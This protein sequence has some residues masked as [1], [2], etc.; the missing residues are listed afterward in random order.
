MA[1]QSLECPNC[2]A[3][4]PDLAGRATVVCPH[5]Q[6]TLHATPAGPGEPAQPVRLEVEAPLQ[7]SPLASVTRVPPADL[8]RIRQLLHEQRK[9]EAVKVYREAMGGSLAEAKNAVDAIQAGLRDAPPAADVASAAAS[10]PDSELLARVRNLLA[11]GNKIEAIKF[12]RAATGVGLAEAKAAVEAIEVGQ[13]PAL[14]GPPATP[15][16]PD[17]LDRVRNLL[18]AGNKIE[19]IKFYRAATGVGLAEAKNTVE[20]I[21]AGTPG[22]RR[23]RRTTI[24]RGPFLTVALVMLICGGCNAYIQN[25]AIYRCAMREL[26]TDAQVQELLGGEVRGSPVMVSP[27]FS[28]E[29][30]FDG[31]TDTDVAFFT[32]LWGSR[33]TGVAYVEAYMRGSSNSA[34]MRATLFT[35]FKRHTLTTFQRI[36]CP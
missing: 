25:T 29:V 34:G 22:L 9:I 21:E 18:A 17:V 12:Y 16:G 2:G 35:G 5:C 24:V 19:A 4:L 32:P 28:Q 6:S 20:L 1:L 3:P 8:A 14:G 30:D 15:A 36:E 11:A 31:T 23:P 7:A 27:G 13:V 33:G 26:V 10:G